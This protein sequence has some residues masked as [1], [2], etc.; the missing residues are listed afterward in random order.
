MCSEPN[1]ELGKEDKMKLES[2]IAIITGAANPKGIGYATAKALAKEGATVILADIM[3]EQLNSSVKEL[4]DLGLR[5]VGISCD[6]TKREDIDSLVNHVLSIFGRID[7]LVN[8]AGGSARIIKKQ[9][10]FIDS[11]PETWDWVIKLNLIGPMLLMR[12]VLPVMVER[13]YGKIVNLASIAG[14]RALGGYADYSASKG[15]LIALSRTVAQEVGDSNI[16]INCVAPG[17]IATRGDGPATFL[18]RL[19]TAEEVADLI[20]FLSSD[21]SSFITGQCFAIDGGRSITS[22]CTKKEERK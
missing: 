2:R 19:G 11:D 9:T 15:G 5:A 6:I 18:G 20:L 10:D 14:I 12:R 17:S 7:I 3:E 1:V 21:D 16:T 22:I 13:K 4:A 8:N